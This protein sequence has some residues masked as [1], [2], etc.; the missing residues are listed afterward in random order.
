MNSRLHMATPRPSVPPAP[1]I[2]RAAYT[3]RPINEPMMQPLSTRI[4]VPVPSGQGRAERHVVEEQQ[5]ARG[6]A[7]GD[8]VDEVVDFCGFAGAGPRAPPNKFSPPPC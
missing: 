2:P 8:R 4:F 5:P 1:F 7:G 3:P 6:A